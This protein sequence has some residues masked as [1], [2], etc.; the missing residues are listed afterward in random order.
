MSIIMLM[1]WA[2]ERLFQDTR[3]KEYWRLLEKNRF[4]PEHQQYAIVTLRQMNPMTY[5][6]DSTVFYKGS[7][8]SN[9]IF[10][11]GNLLANKNV[12]KSI[13]DAA[14]QGQKNAR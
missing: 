10:V 7:L 6:G 3:L 13:F 14:V 5:T 12:L 11:Q 4:D 1:I 2:E 8:T 9:S